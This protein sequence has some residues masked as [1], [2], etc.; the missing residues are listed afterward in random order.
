MTIENIS[1][2]ISTKECC[3]PRRGP[4][5]WPPGLQSDA[6]PTDPPRPAAFSMNQSVRTGNT[7][8][9]RGRI[10]VSVAFFN[11]LIAEVRTANTC[12]TTACLANNGTVADVKSMQRITSVLLRYYRRYEWQVADFIQSNNPIIT[13]SSSTGKNMRPVDSALGVLGVRTLIDSATPR[14]LSILQKLMI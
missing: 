10:P 8:W 6:H 3:R 12:L 2:S 14:T 13:S 11:C 7:Q 9:G 1:W 5:P 4:N